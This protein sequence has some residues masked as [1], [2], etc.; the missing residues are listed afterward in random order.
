VV[1]SESLERGALADKDRA[2]RLG[3]AGN[4]GLYQ[5]VVFLLVVIQQRALKFQNFVSNRVGFFQ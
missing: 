4:D 5:D 3:R 1:V 2:L